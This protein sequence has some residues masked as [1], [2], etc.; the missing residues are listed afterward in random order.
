[1]ATFHVFDNEMFA[2]KPQSNLVQM[3]RGCG[4]GHGCGG[5]HRGCGGCHR[6]CGGW[7]RG[8][9][10]WG[11]CGG[12]GWRPWCVSRGGCHFC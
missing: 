6:G 12:C 10:G 11:G 2:A 1:L 4:C 3:A 7:H 8:C 5:C 9:G